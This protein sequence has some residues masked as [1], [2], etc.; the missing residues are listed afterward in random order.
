MKSY[1]LAKIIFYQLYFLNLFQLQ[2]GLNGFLW[3]GV[4]GRPPCAIVPMGNQSPLKELGVR[5]SPPAAKISEKAELA[6]WLLRCHKEVR[7]GSFFINLVFVFWKL[8][9]LNLESI[10]TVLGSR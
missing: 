7:R 6:P 5:N 2:Y 4:G 1:T 10:T 3:A 9:A 8:P